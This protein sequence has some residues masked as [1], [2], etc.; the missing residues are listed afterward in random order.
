MSIGEFA[1]QPRLSPKPLRL[2][3]ELGVLVPAR[4]DPD[5]GYRY[6]DADQLE[7]ARLVASFRQLGIPL[8]DIS[9]I[10]DQEPHVAAER[11]AAYWAGIEADHS[12]RRELTNV[13]VSR[14]NGKRPL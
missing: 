9:E 2:Y 11:V 14:L 7:T 6:Y 12:M 5:F 4:V 10:V 1:R 13:L 3:D 8:T